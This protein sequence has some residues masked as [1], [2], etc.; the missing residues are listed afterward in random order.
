[1]SPWTPNIVIT[2]P[3]EGNP[4][5]SLTVIARSAT[6]TLGAVLAIGAVAR[7]PARFPPK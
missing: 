1:L 5:I 7:T 4:Q 6:I 3:A 2:I